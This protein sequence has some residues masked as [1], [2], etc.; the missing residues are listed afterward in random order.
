MGICTNQPVILNVL[1]PMTYPVRSQPNNRISATSTCRSPRFWAARATMLPR[2]GLADQG[3][4]WTLFAL[5]DGW[6]SFNWL[7]VWNIFFPIYWE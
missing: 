5:S 4:R 2:P 7:V 6:I 3:V 1:V